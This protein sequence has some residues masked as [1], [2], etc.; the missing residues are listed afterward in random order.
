MFFK[1]VSELLHIY[2]HGFLGMDEL[3]TGHEMTI[4]WRGLLLP[5]HFLP[6]LT[7]G[8]M[9]SAL[10]GGGAVP[11]GALFLDDVV[12]FFFPTILTCSLEPV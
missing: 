8:H 10:R 9:A 11:V 1:P 4:V 6:E 12:N 2:P 5:F 7:E 3:T